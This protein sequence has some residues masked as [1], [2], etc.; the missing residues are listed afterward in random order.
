M[1][2]RALE[3]SCKDNLV[4]SVGVGKVTSSRRNRISKDK[5]GFGVRKF[6]L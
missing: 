3:W 5:S 2:E 1:E 6:R 4:V